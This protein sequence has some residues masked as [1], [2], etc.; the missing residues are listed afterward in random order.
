MGQILLTGQPRLLQPGLYRIDYQHPLARGL[1]YLDVLNGSYWGRPA[2]IVT[3]DVPGSN[4]GA[5]IINATTLGTKQGPGGTGLSSSTNTDY[6]EISTGVPGSWSVRLNQNQ[7][8][9]V[10]YCT[11]GVGTTA[12]GVNRTLWNDENAAGSQLFSLLRYI[13]N[14]WYV[15]WSSGGR[16]V[17]A[18]T[19]WT[20]GLTCTMACT[21]VNGGTTKFWMNGS[22]R[23]TAVGTA[24]NDTISFRHSIVGGAR[25]G[26]VWSGWVYWV[27]YWDR[28]LADDELFYLNQNPMSFMY[29]ASDEVQAEFLQ[30][31]GGGPSGTGFMVPTPQPTNIRRGMRVIG[32]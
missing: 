12:D 23:G 21:Y 10:G 26:G 1:T 13:D 24:T 4:K 6:Y 17:L 22:V 27:G 2:N 3:I 11:M 5:F 16:V 28:V 7:G 30:S 14:N 25:L 18:D 20:S 19:L 29:P 9:A 8:T 15:G 32:Y 31:G